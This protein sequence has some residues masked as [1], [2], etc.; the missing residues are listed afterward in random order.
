MSSFKQVRTWLLIAFALET[1]TATYCLKLS[2]WIPVFSV[3]YFISGIAISILIAEGSTLTIRMQQGLTNKNAN[4]YKFLLLGAMAI[5]AFLTASYWFDEIPIDPDYADMLPVIRTMNERF[6]SG[7]WHKIYDTIPELW[8]GTRPI[9]LPAMWLPFL[10]AVIFHFDMRWVTVAGVVFSFCLFLYFLKL[11]KFFSFSFVAVLLGAILFWWLFAEND[12]HGFITLSEEGVIVLYYSILVIAIVSGNVVFV[13]IITSIC[14]LS[15]YALI[16]W[17]PAYLL[18][19]Y[20]QGRRNQIMVYIGI[21]MLCF[22]VLFVLPFGWKPFVQLTQLPAQYIGFSKLVW[23]DSPEVFWLSLGL[24]KFFGPERATLLHWTLIVLSWTIPTSFV[25][26]Y[27]WLRKKRNWPN[28]AV[29]SLKISLVIFYNFIDVPYLYLFYTS[30]F[31]S[32]IAVAIQIYSTAENKAEQV[33]STQS[34]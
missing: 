25:I 19:L 17:I 13:A 30:S 2:S 21:G 33:V 22:I 27:Y 34:N 1:A 4:L 5:L 18:C 12:V 10:P 20:L 31:V 9:Y 3:I 14:V 8:S 28:L 29:A 32:L 11:E 7:Q 6:L 16:G 15:R 24:A 23:K 26:I